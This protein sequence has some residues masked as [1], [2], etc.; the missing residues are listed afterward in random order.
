MDGLTNRTAQQPAKKLSVPIRYFCSVIEDG[1]INSY[2]LLGN[3]Q[4]FKSEACVCVLVG[5]LCGVLAW[6][7]ADPNQ[8]ARLVKLVFC[9]IRWLLL[10]VTENRFV[11][12]EF[13]L[14]FFLSFY[15]CSVFLLL[16]YAE[17][18]TLLLSR[19]KF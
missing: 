19:K 1:L 5:W 15:F 16:S 17:A 7:P 8:F 4:S 3:I 10:M 12:N 9:L 13:F 11:F 14:V 6:W 2:V 18:E